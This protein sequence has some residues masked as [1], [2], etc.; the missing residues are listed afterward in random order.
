MRC[1]SRR[2][3]A[4]PSCAA[5]YRGDWQRLARSGMYDADGRPVEGYRYFF[6]TLSAPSFGAVHRVPKPWDKVR[7]RCACGAAHSPEDV[8]LR[9]LP[10]N[11]DA[12]DYNGQVRWHGG[13][14]RLWSSSVDAMRRQEPSLE[15]FVVREVQARMA[16]H[17]HAIVRVPA[18]SP[19]SAA[20][21]GAAARRAEAAHPATGEMMAWGQKGVQDREITARRRHEVD[22]PV[23]MSTAATRVI[24]YVSKALNYSLK[25][26]T[27]GQ[28]V[29]GS[30]PS[31]DRLA[32]VE[33][34]RAAAR[35][36]V[37]CKD[38][39]DE[40][41]V[42]CIRAAHRNLGYGGHTVTMSRPTENRT[43]WSFSQ[44]TRKQIREERMAW[45]AANYPVADDDTNGED[46]AW[47][48]RFA[49]DLRAERARDAWEAKEHAQA[50]P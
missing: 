43:G 36:H 39:P 19:S 29:A 33:R 10:V 12:Y 28:D 37:R 6:I 49:N 47:W 9:G 2:S 42:N 18:G 8:E 11:I 44:L 24:S 34:L 13:L 31:P 35:L 38:C 17:A 14:S 45:A 21:L 4:C 22:L 25:D 32:F 40:G 26:I 3:A 50:A 30:D 15:Y 7:R 16:L 5:Q 46:Q 1:Q 20:S 48:A 27:P 41:P 23:N